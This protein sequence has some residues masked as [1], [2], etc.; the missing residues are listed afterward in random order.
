M[1]KTGPSRLR[2]FGFW[3]TPI[4]RLLA[5]GAGCKDLRHNGQSPAITLKAA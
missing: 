2:P 5:Q 3:L 4:T 1:A